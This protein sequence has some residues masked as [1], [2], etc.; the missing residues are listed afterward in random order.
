MHT[1]MAESMART[2]QNEIK[3]SRKF[4]EFTYVFKKEKKKDC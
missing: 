3:W 1:G 2:E 4:G